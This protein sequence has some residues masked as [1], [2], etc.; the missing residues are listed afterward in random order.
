MAAGKHKFNLYGKTLQIFR[1]PKSHLLWAG[2]H[3]RRD[4]NIFNLA[5]V[6]VHDL[7]PRRS[8][9]HRGIRLACDVKWDGTDIG[10]IVVD[11]ADF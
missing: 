11:A 3:R 8:A 1:F 9:R 4:C 2:Q 10:M 5:G 6:A 7:F